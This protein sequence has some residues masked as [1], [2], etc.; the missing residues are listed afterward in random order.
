MD[1]TSLPSAILSHKSST[2]TKSN[3][4][5]YAILKERKELFLILKSRL[6]EEIRMMENRILIIQKE[7][8][9]SQ[10]SLKAI[11]H[12]VNKIQEIENMKAKLHI[13]V[14]NIFITIEIEC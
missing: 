11:K 2:A 14:T 6:K 10:R 8:L 4:N 5:L 9:S 13:Q 1:S 3:D 12:K 7:Q